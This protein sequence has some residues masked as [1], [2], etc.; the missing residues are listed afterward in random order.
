V[1][2]R[3]TRSAVPGGAEDEVIPQGTVTEGDG[4][5]KRPMTEWVVY[6]DGRHF[7]ER[8]LTPAD[9]QKVG[10]EGPLVIWDRSNGHRVKKSVLTDFLDEDQFHSFILADPR[11]EL[12]LD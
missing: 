12:V 4:S 9:W 8:R 2:T 7:E 6:T 3:T 10:V 11:F 5:E 1:A